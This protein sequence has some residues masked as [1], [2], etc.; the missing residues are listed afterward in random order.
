MRH[1]LLPI[2]FAALAALVACGD[3][4]GDSGDAPVPEDGPPSGI[5]FLHAHEANPGALDMVLR[6][7]DT[8]TEYRIDGVSL[9]KAS[10]W[11][12]V[13]A[14]IYTALFFR[15]GTT[16]VLADL[17]IDALNVEEGAAKTVVVAQR[18][19]GAPTKSQF[20]DDINAPSENHAQLRFIH[21]AQ[22]GPVDIYNDAD[23]T[24]IVTNIGNGAFQNYQEFP[25]ARYDFTVY[26]EGLMDVALARGVQ[27]PLPP[28]SVSTVVLVGNADP[29]G[30][31]DVTD[32]TAEL[33]LLED[34]VF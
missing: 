22:A 25:A 8:E 17:A 31:G 29:N 24:R 7:R 20:V 19:D 12:T 6:D 27:L 32:S 16:D 13:P 3:D 21:L 1:Y 28:A 30:D 10:G 5:R 2:C 9:H 18:G 23:G 33:L 15:S 11:E 14:G 26:D 34:Y 4:G